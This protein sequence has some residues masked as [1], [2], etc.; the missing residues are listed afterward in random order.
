[1]L[2]HPPMLVHPLCMAASCIH[3]RSAHC[4][5]SIVCCRPVQAQAPTCGVL[6]LYSRPCGSAAAADVTDR[7][8]P[9]PCSGSDHES[10]ENHPPQPPPP[11][12]TTTTTTL[13]GLLQASPGA[14]TDTR[15]VGP[16]TVDPVAARR[17]LM[18]QLETAERRR[19]ESEIATLT[20]AQQVR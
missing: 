19:A 1:M 9:P 16:L 7:P 17:L 13:C 18:S 2:V 11:S 14:G 20:G 8:P 3:Q 6:A 12:S 4:C 15:R 5:V 10:H